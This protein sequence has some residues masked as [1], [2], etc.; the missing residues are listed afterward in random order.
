MQ[1]VN[2]LFL[3][4]FSREVKRTAGV[5]TTDLVGRMLLLTKNHFRQGSAEYAIEKEG[6]FIFFHYSCYVSFLFC[7]KAFILLQLLFFF[8]FA[9]I[10]LYI[11]FIIK[12]SIFCFLYKCMP[13]TLNT[14]QTNT[15]FIF[16]YKYC[17]DCFL[18][19]Y[20]N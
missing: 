11:T 16:S 18:Y 7:Y 14:Y 5:S 15:I 6:Q 13:S 4:L 20:Y 8:S 2:F 10:C 17:Y 19:S 9:F 1:V 12:T 3:F